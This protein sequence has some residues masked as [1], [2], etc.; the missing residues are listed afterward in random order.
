MSHIIHGS[1][2]EWAIFDNVI[3][4][5]ADVFTLWILTSANWAQWIVTFPEDLT[6]KITIL[7]HIQ[8]HKV[9]NLLASMKKTIF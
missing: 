2:Q 3:I 5:A 4:L 7:K 9:L 6:L 1:F 8:S